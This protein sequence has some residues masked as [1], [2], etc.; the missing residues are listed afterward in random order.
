MP[1]AEVTREGDRV[2]VATHAVVPT[3]ALITGWAVEQTIELANFSVTRPTLEDIYL[4]LTGE[5]SQ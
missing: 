1:G 5:A 3:T 4:E 2:L